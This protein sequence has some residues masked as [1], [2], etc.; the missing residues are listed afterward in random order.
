MNSA[1][2]NNAPLNSA[3]RS[4]EARVLVVPLGHDAGRAQATMVRQG[5]H[6]LMTVRG[7]TASTGADG[8]VSRLGSVPLGEHGWRPAADELSVTDL[9]D[10]ADVMVLLATDLAE[11]PARLCLDLAAAARANGSLIAGL[12]VGSQTWDAP[13]GNTAMA[14]LRQAVDMLVVVR[15]TDLAAHFL[16]VLRGGPREA[17][18]AS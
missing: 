17:A 8:D 5:L 1:R 2:P 18:L 13:E 16:D 10:T 12:V 4:Y 6:G 14:V 9:V 15:G 3:R 11:V 7:V